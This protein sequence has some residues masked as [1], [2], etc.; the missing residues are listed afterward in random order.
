MNKIKNNISAK[1][2]AT[3]EEL[4]KGW[5]I[6]TINDVHEK[7]FT[8]TTP[9]SQEEKYY[10]EGNIN[11]FA[12]SDFQDQ[13]YLINSTRK[14]TPLA[15]VEGKAKLFP[16]KSLLLIAIGATIG[17]VGVIKKK[18]S[19]NQ[20]IT[21]IN[22]KKNID[23]D[24][25]Y[26]WFVHNKKLIIDKA[27]AAT[28]PIINQSGIKELPIIVPPL[29][30]QQRIVQQLDALFERIDKA[31]QLTRE[32]LEHCTHLLPAALNEV[33]EF[34]EAKRPISLAKHVEFIGG[35]Q[36]AK[37]EFSYE[38]KEG[39]IRLIQIRD[40]KSDNHKVFIKKESAK[41]FCNE[42]DIMI[43]RYGPP[44]FQILRGLKG[45]YNVALM[46]AVPDEKYLTKDYLYWFLQNPNI[47]NYIIGIS[48]RSAGQ[49]GVN[50]DAL[51]KY[52]INLPDLTIQQQI[53]TYLNQLS[54]KQ[55]Q[56][57]Q[58]YSKQLQ[59]LQALKSSLLDGAFK[60]EL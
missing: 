35:S 50:K 28:L 56:L 34:N 39:Y 22:F 19:S 30:E 25:A 20:Q 32:N 37:E 46:K 47:Q 6:S 17:K 40:Y 38:E 16:E 55:Q 59:Q 10:S 58:H 12:P 21:C 11:W 3:A 2:P 27:S 1:Q 53:V 24:F 42:D 57:Q 7:V 48:Q 36:P 41:R 51:E 29:P 43:G 8:G 54:S 23:V 60:G 13:R 52:E 33:F 18:A 5:E 26:Y 31:I 45:A 15:I 9:P 4:P 44:V 14:I 49:S